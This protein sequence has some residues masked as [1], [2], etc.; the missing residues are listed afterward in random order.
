MKHISDEAR[1]KAKSLASYIRSLPDFAVDES[2]AQTHDHIG[3]IIVDAIL[4]SGMNY[5]A[6]VRPRVDSL[7][8]EYPEARTTSGFLALADAVGLRTLIRWNGKVKIERILG[9][10]Y[11][12]HNEGIETRDSLRIWLEQ[13]ANVDRLRQLPGIGNMT[14]DYF[15]MLAG[16]E[17]IAPD[18]LIL[19]FVKRAGVRPGSYSESRDMLEALAR[20]LSVSPIALGFSIWQYMAGTRKSQGASPSR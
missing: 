15:K 12:L 4:Q 10:A 9:A 1:H 8:E 6:I 20:R 2:L 11:F 13:A 18:G 14:A 3:A 16:I 19:R 7:R 17:T 5:E